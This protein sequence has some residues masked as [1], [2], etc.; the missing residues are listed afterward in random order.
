MQRALTIA[1]S[2]SGGGAGI[3]ADLKAFARFGV[4]GTSALTLVTS[5]NTLGV[6]GVHLLPPEVVTSQID[7]VLGDLGTDAAKT[8]AIGSSE[9][10]ARVA[11]RIAHHRIEKLV[12]D[13]VMISKHGDPLLPPDAIAMLQ[14]RLLPLALL[15]TPNTHEA[16]A[17]TGLEVADLASMRE[18]ARRLHGMGPKAVLV[19]GGAL[20]GRLAVDVFFDGAD[21]EELTAP[22]LEGKG[23]H[24]TGCTYSAGI[25]ALL[26]KGRELKLAVREAKAYVTR[27]IALSP[28][29][30]RGVGPV[31]HLA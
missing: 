28:P 6:Q 5:Q 14:E 22:R 27:A 29:L 4:F 16:A 18:A 31:N 19:K 12:V 7:S 23:T 13:P 9:L 17:L 8:G 3:Q 1:G 24:G 21:F 20:S 26:A 10:I 30:G 15:V 2:D 25:T 11:E